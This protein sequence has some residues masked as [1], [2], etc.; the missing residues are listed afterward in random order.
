MLQASSSTLNCAPCAL[1]ENG[2]A[3]FADSD[4]CKTLRLENYVKTTFGS[5]GPESPLFEL[6]VAKP[7][8]RRGM[9]GIPCI[10]YYLGIIRFCFGKEFMLYWKL[11]TQ[12]YCDQLEI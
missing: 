10:L 8:A 2:Y 12:G 9:L 1:S 5:G 3:V 7:H 6:F 4:L 11:F